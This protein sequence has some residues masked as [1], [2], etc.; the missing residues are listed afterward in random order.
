MAVQTYTRANK[1]SVS[2]HRAQVSSLP[3][4]QLRRPPQI[5][6]K[7]VSHVPSGN[8]GS[9]FCCVSGNSCFGFAT[10]SCNHKLE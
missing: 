1:S 4:P 3:L 7:V 8:M 10:I 2:Q 9:F 6:Q 5:R